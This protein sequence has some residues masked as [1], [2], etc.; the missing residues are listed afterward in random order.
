MTFGGPVQPTFEIRSVQ[1][2]DFQVLMTLNNS[3]MPH[4]NNLQPRQVEWLAKVACSFPVAYAKGQLAGFL[5]ALPRGLE[6]GSLNYQYFMQ[7]YQEF[8]YIDRLVV[9]TPHRRQGLAQQLYQHFFG[10]VPSRVIA[11]EVNIDPPNPGSMALHEKLGFRQVGK[12]FTEGGSKQ[13]SLMIKEAAPPKEEV[14]IV[15]ALLS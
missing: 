6:Y 3:N 1:P 10:A 2:A 12:Q 14:D 7:R 8:T 9:A 4:V 13:V 11:C 15:S 5:V